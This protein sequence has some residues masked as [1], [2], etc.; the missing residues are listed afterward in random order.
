MKSGIMSKLE[1]SLVHR[2][3][4]RFLSFF[5]FFWCQTCL[6]ICVSNSPGSS[7]RKKFLLKPFK[8][9][10]RNLLPWKSWPI[11]PLVFDIRTYVRVGKILIC[12]GLKK[13]T[14]L[15][16]HKKAFWGISSAVKS[17]FFILLKNNELAN[18]TLS[19]SSGYAYI[20]IVVVVPLKGM[21]NY[22][23]QM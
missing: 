21:V 8:L 10:S 15:F 19:V 5:P 9:L 4:N 2:A 1:R 6:S 20:Q 18:P 22:L 12:S 14:N 13:P 17:A 16:R 23:G 7:L 3:V 11:L